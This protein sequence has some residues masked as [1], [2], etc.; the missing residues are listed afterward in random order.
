M[1]RQPE[2]SRTWN[3]EKW[4]AAAVLFLLFFL[5]MAGIYEK[6]LKKKDY[7]P[8][9]F[10]KTAEMGTPVPPDNMNYGTIAT[11][12]GIV[13]SLAGT[14]Y[15]QR[16]GSVEIYL[17]NPP[18]NAANLMAEIVDEEGERLY[19]TGVIRPG[20]YVERMQP[21]KEI[22]NEAVKIEMRIYA[23]ELDSWYSRGTVS[24]QN[25]LQPY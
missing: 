16:D 12:T 23:F 8:P 14:I 22:P 4:L 11:E 25:T 24:L 5:V 20:E 2:K 6:I 19:A 9:T 7:I 15:Q 21:E 17:T 18:E 3:R 10:D 1:K 13:F